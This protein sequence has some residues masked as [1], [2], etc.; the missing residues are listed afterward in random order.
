MGPDALLDA[1]PGALGEH[2]FRSMG[3]QVSVLAPADRRDAWPRTRA[4]I[5]E[6]DE[7][8]SRFRR[9]S[10]L[11]RL[12]DADGR[13]FPASRKM[14]TVLEAAVRAARATDGLFDP[15][16]GGRMRELGYD[17][18]FV[19]LPVDRPPLP[20]GDWR[21]G[22][23]REIVVDA[24]RGTVRLPR[25]H[26]LDLGGIV[27]GMAV[28]AALDALVAAGLPFAAVNAGG[29]LS[30]FGLP[31]GADAWNVEIE[32]PHPTVVAV[33][34]GALATSSVLRRRWRVAGSELHHLLDPRTGTP[35]AGPIV[36]A[37]VAAA[38][39]AQAEV[40][41]K[42]AML[43]DLPGAVGRLESSRLAALLVTAA[44]EAWRV[45]AWH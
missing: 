15:L 6:W 1:R 41:A 26:R 3:C 28:D 22:A 42:V 33:R 40:A 39:C 4:V 12:N 16:L 30:V 5:D 21:P 2:H 37:T 25:G 31:P 8:F 17:R 14:L 11:E 43:S 38:S 9:D 23:W 44:G 34:G 10:E 45:G 29:D 19:E 7:Q 35:A 32:G 36:Q 24:E 20:L 27:K 13:P 18:T